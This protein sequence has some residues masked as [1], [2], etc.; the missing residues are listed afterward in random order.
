VVFARVRAAYDDLGRRLPVDRLVQLVLHRGKEAL[1]G[2]LT[3]GKH[4]LQVVVD[5]LRLDVV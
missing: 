3:V 2:Q 4:L 1:S 5:G